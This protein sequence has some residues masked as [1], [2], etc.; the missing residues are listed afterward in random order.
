MCR[1]VEIGYGIVVQKVK[2]EEKMRVKYWI[3]VAVL[4]FAII[5]SLFF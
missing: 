5:I 2:A 3:V 4:L 1:A